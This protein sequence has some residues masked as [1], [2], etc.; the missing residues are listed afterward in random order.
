MLYNLIMK[1]VRKDETIVQKEPGV[2]FLA[3]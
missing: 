1:I 2:A 3:I